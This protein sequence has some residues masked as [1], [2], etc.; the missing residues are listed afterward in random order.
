MNEK[1]IE[2]QKLMIKNHNDSTTNNNSINNN[3][4]SSNSNTNN[5]SINDNSNNLNSNNDNNNKEGNTND[6]NENS[7]YISENNQNKNLNIYLNV[8]NDNQGSFSFLNNNYNEQQD[9]DEDI[10]E[11]IYIVDKDKYFEEKN[12]LNTFDIKLNVHIDHTQKDKILFYDYDYKEDGNFGDKKQIYRFKC[13]DSNCQG[14]YQLNLNENKNENDKN[15]LFSKIQEHSLDYNKHDYNNNPTKGQNKY[16]EIMTKYPNIK[17]I[18][19]I[20]VPDNFD[21]STIP[22]I[23]DENTNE[24]N[25]E[26]NDLSLQKNQI[27]IN[28]DDNE[29]EKYSLESDLY[30]KNK[31]DKEDDDDY[32]SN[33]SSYK[34]RSR[35]KE[36][37]KKI[38]KKI[39]MNHNNK[40][41]EKEKERSK[42]KDK[43]KDKPKGKRHKPTILEDYQRYIES[44]VKQI[45]KKR[46]QLYYKPQEYTKFTISLKNPRYV[47]A[48]LPYYKKGREALGKSKARE[49]WLR[50]M[51]FKYGE[52]TTLGP[53]YYKDK[54]DGKI[55]KFAVNNL[56]SDADNRKV[57]YSCFRDNC[58]GRG[59]L[60]VEND[61]FTIIE[62]HSL[63]RS[64]CTD[65]KRHQAIVDYYNGH[66]DIIYIQTLRVFKQSK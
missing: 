50:Y 15:I 43:D 26:I 65:I 48:Y 22:S 8:S 58:Q 57:T 44:G 20:T 37:K 30:D 1:I 52:E 40:E 47:Y 31:I 61:I 66:P 45:K 42:Q 19:I 34:A 17:H 29:D 63:R 38:T 13:S 35:N 46:Q 4:N 54:N 60:N 32:Y 11:M 3:Y 12:I 28:V 18:Q 2:V 25:N 49:K 41:R 59:V 51:A 33:T 14:I 16:Q 36:N 9:I 62:P 6:I 24:D 21:F 64:L 27:N 39:K 56:S 23:G 55:Y 7:N 10:I 53:I 5:N